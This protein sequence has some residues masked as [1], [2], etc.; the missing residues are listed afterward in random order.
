MKIGNY[1]I[2]LINSGTK[3]EKYDTITHVKKLT[4]FGKFELPIE[5]QIMT[6]EE[7]DVDD[8]RYTKEQALDI[9][10]AE[11]KTLAGQNVPNGAEVIDTEYK[12]FYTDNEVQVRV[13]NECIE[14]VGIKEKL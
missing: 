3:F 13:T 12:V 14:K 6:F 5:A 10:K 7:F 1:T 9:A 4:L 8:V 11:A 2:N